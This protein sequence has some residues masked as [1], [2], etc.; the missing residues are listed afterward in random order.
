MKHETFVY[1]QNHGYRPIGWIYPKKREQC[2]G[3]GDAFT[4]FLGGLLVLGIIGL[5]VLA[6]VALKGCT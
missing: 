5:L 4:E 1:L 3:S 2:Y 6:A